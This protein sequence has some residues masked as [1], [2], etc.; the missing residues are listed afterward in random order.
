MKPRHKIVKGGRLHFDRFLEAQ[1]SS[2]ENPLP[3]THTTD[4]FDLRDIVSSAEIQPSYCE[5]FREELSYF[6]YGRPA[7]RKNGTIQANSL[8]AYAPIVLIFKP[9]V[10]DDAIT[11]FPFDSG[12][13]KDEKYLEVMHHRMAVEDFGLE[14][15]LEKIGKLVIFFFGSNNR[16]YD[17]I[18][19]RKRKAGAGEFE[20]QGY[21]ELVVYRGKNE[22]D[23]RS[24]TIEVILDNHLKLKDN[25]LAVIV[26]SSFLKDKSVRKCFKA[27]TST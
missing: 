11:A 23:D 25:L 15:S 4:A 16:Y 17:Q 12:A 6:F 7:Y 5:I 24:T 3:L 22:R 18:P 14:P 8:A 26:P 9:S 19:A 10:A 21:S 1:T 2:T 13:F 27:W 20:A